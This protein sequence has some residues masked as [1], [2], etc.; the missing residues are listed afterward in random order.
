[1]Q[2]TYDTEY[3]TLADGYFRIVIGAISS[4]HYINGYI[5][6]SHVMGICGSSSYSQVMSLFVRKGTKIR[7]S[8]DDSS[9]GLA[10]FY[11]LS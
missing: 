5:G 2:L 9:S 1:M 8:G 7:Y 10:Q 4:A 6:N 11:P 3:T